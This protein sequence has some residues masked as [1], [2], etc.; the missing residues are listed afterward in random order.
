MVVFPDYARRLAFSAD[1]D[2]RVMYTNGIGYQNL[3]PDTTAYETMP[4]WSPDGNYVA[5]V[6]NRS[7]DEDIFIAPASAPGDEAQQINI[8][9]QPG[10]DITPAWSPDGR[11][12]AF[13]SNRY[14]SWGIYVLELILTEPMSDNPVLLG[15]LRRTHNA[16]YEGHPAWSPDG[17]Y[18]A[19]TSDQGHRWQIRLME[20]SGTGQQ[21]FPGTEWFLSTAY[22]AWSPDGERLAFAGRKKQNWDIYVMSRTGEEITQLTTDPAQDWG[23][24][25]SPD[26][27]WIAFTSDRSGNGDIYLVRPDVTEEVRLTDNPAVELYPAWEP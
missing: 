10:Q 1:G 6:S 17:Q 23:P 15:P 9:Y 25:W 16:R 24:R 27:E 11:Q 3:T 20:R 14:D 4:V 5:F 18:I 19:Y 22:P 8:T 21:A 26:G 7:G 12:L 2:L 13:A